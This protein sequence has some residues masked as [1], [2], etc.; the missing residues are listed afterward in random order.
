MLAFGPSPLG[1]LRTNDASNVGYQLREGVLIELVP[2]T[3]EPTKDGVRQRLLVSLKLREPDYWVIRALVK[4]HRGYEFEPAKMLRSEGE[5]REVFPP[6]RRGNQE[7][8]P[9]SR[10]RFRLGDEPEEG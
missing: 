8:P 2:P 9:K 7:E 6:E 5:I 4:E 1:S 3:I 10:R